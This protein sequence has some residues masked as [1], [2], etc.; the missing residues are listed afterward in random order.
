M[1]I[2]VLLN[3]EKGMTRMMNCINNVLQTVYN[4][5]RL[6]SKVISLWT[7]IVSVLVLILI[8]VYSK[9][10][11]PNDKKAQYKKT[12]N[13][14]TILYLLLSVVVIPLLLA[15]VSDYSEK[16]Q[17]I[18]RLYDEGNEL[19]ENNKYGEAHAKWDKLIELDPGNSRYYYLKGLTY[20]GQLKFEE[21]LEMYDKAIS[22]DDSYYNY[23]Q[24]KAYIL[25]NLQRYDEALEA[26]SKACEMQNDS[27]ECK[28]FKIEM[29]I[30]NKDYEQANAICKELIDSEVKTGK[31]YYK[32][33]I[34]LY[35]MGNYRES[36]IAIKNALS[37]DD[38]NTDYVNFLDVINKYK[39][40]LSDR[41]RTSLNE[42]GCAYVKIGWYLDAKEY[43]IEAL[44]Y[45]EDNAVLNNNVAYCCYRLGEFNDAKEYNDKAIEIDPKPRYI[46]LGRLISG[47]INIENG[48]ENVSQYLELGKANFEY[49]EIDNALKYFKL[50]QELDPNDSSVD[51]YITIC[52]DKKRCDKSDG[53]DYSLIY[54]LIKQLTDTEMYYGAYLECNRYS[55][56]DL[57]KNDTEFHTLYGYNLF[58]LG[59]YEDSLAEYNEALTISPDNEECKKNVEILKEYVNE[60]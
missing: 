47:N 36:E 37:I 2:Q 13:V 3:N 42:L 40:V 49:G 51:V 30:Q 21:A 56:N 19:L 29:L 43:H 48:I 54:G 53:N 17:E 55:E 33:A 14:L 27:V 46:I 20:H 57:F 59:K 1:I 10:S 35:R 45:D 32:Q 41:N 34:C 9:S 38:S 23:Y 44:S 8:K 18:Q 52:V 28:I 5:V 39:D 58:K 26:I 4:L 60:E 25:N 24:K 22:L 50:A 7:L 31:V 15:S 12:S 6:N 16:Q 11:N